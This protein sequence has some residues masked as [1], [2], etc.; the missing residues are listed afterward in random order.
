MLSHPKCSYQNCLLFLFKS[1]QNSIPATPTTTP[2]SNRSRTASHQRLP[3]AVEDEELL[4][5]GESPVPGRHTISGTNA[6]KV[7]VIKVN[8]TDKDQ[9]NSSSASI[10]KQKVLNIFRARSSSS[11]TA[12]DKRKVFSRVSQKS[13]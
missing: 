1:P 2:V 8:S 9:E 6:T 10:L 3:T 5:K 4:T 7:L 13:Y 12:E 11:A